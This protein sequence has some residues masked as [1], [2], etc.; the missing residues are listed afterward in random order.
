MGERGS[1]A[2]GVALSRPGSRSSF[3]GSGAVRGDSAAWTG[4]FGAVWAGQGTG[5]EGQED[6]GDLAVPS[7]RLAWSIPHN[8]PNGV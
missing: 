6:N 8:E 5:F 7:T 2:G 4:R 1:G 3:P